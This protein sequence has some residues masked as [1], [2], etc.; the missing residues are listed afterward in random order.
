MRGRRRGS[1]IIGV[2]IF[3]FVP[4][5]RQGLPKGENRM[6]QAN[7]LRS[8][9]AGVYLHKFMTAGSP[10][11]RRRLGEKVVVAPG[12]CRSNDESRASQV[13]NNEGA[14]DRLVSGKRGG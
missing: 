7:R 12:S 6:S 9:K 2:S 4:M 14:I 8:C 13:V 10:C 1:L 11:R 3:L 5:E